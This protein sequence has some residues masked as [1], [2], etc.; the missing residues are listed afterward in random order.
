MMWGKP[1]RP[2]ARTLAWMDQQDSEQGDVLATI[3]RFLAS[4]DE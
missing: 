3:A 1:Q 4:I 2:I